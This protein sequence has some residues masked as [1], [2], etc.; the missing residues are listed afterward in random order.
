MGLIRGLQQAAADQAELQRRARTRT[1]P[2]RQVQLWR[3]EARLQPHG[4]RAFQHSADPQF[5]AKLRDMIDLL[6][7][8]GPRA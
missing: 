7:K 3:T 8:K 4:T 6:E 5:E 1:L 2:H